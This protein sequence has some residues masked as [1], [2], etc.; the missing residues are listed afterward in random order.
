MSHVKYTVSRFENRSGVVSW[1]VSGNFNG[2]RGRR[3]FRRRGDA[4]AE[5]AVLEIQALQATSGLHTVVTA[6]T[7]ERVREAEALFYRMQGKARPLSFYVDYALANYREPDQQKPLDQGI[8]EYI[9]S[10]ERELAQ[11]Q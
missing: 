4:A 3:N 2:I 8:A 1:R 11:D 9:A 6:L 5:K 7:Q 10:K